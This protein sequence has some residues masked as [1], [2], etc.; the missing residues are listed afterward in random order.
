MSLRV[1][2]RCARITNKRK[3]LTC[4]TCSKKFC[5]GCVEVRCAFCPCEHSVG[6]AP[7]LYAELQKTT[8][9]INH[10]LETDFC[11]ECRCKNH[12]CVELVVCKTCYLGRKPTGNRFYKHL[13]QASGLPLSE[14]AQRLGLNLKEE[15]KKYS[16]PQ[17]SEPFSRACR[18]CQRSLRFN[19]F[20]VGTL[21]DLECRDCAASAEVSGGAPSL[22]EVIVDLV[23]DY[24][25][26]R[27]QE[28]SP[29][30][31]RRLR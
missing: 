16:Q 23:V 5:C 11:E 20:H 7:L 15:E 29:A 17:F 1:C 25:D 12:T 21:E 13:I 6:Y 28:E 19:E 2:A 26:W 10:F 24:T 4:E 18:T 9:D 22:P 8:L 31:R 3:T 30:K 14:A 27:A